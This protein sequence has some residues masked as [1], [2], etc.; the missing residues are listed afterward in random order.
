MLLLVPN[1]RYKRLKINNGQ[2]DRYDNS[3]VKRH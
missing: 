3:S 2:N 1:Q